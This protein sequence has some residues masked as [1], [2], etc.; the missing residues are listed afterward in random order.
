MNTEFKIS[1]RKAIG[2]LS[3]RIVALDTAYPGFFTDH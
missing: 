2:D 1:R 3:L